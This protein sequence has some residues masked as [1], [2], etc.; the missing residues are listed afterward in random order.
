MMAEP[1]H[2]HN[3]LHY[4]GSLL[5]VMSV[6]RRA[7]SPMSTDAIT[8]ELMSLKPDEDRKRLRVRVRSAI[9]ALYSQGRLTR[10]ERRTE[11]NFIQYLYTCSTGQN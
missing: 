1:Y 11:K 7:T 10:S 2:L 8:D 5:E 4:P 6:L 9:K 3:R